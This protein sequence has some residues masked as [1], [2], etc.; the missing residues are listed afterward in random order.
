MYNHVYGLGFEPGGKTC[1]FLETDPSS[2]RNQL[3]VQNNSIAGPRLQ[4]KEDFVI[5][6]G[7]QLRTPG[8]NVHLTT[9]INAIDTKVKGV[10]TQ[11]AKDK[12]AQVDLT[13]ELAKLQGASEYVYNGARYRKW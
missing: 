1:R 7:H 5:L 4:G 3:I 8:G 2:R 12:A 13:K 11:S 10:E 6:S 9:H